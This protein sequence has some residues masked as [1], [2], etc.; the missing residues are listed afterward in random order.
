[1]TR[2]EIRTAI[3][4]LL[5]DQIEPYYW[6]DAELNRYIQDACD[7]I[8]KRTLC[9]KDS[10][11]TAY[12]Q[13]TMLA[14]TIHYSY[15]DGVIEIESVRKS[16]DG[17]PLVRTTFE[18]VLSSQPLWETSTNYPTHF[19]TDF[20]MDT[21]SM[22]GRLT[23]VTTET[24]NMTVCRMPAV[25][26]ADTSVPDIPTRFHTKTFNWVL[27]RCFNKQDSETYNP[28][29]GENHRMAFEGG[30][31]QLGKGGDIQQIILQMNPF[32]PHVSNARYF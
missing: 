7:E 1:M 28:Q 23:S 17:R 27:Y 15:P 18:S 30:A 24:L 29:K 19:L 20:S 14:N 5:D 25:L 13:I 21:I 3:R 2:K 4:A 8:A 6:S 12:C 9:I 22:V 32:Y 10:I 16:W 31:G 11:T 26:T